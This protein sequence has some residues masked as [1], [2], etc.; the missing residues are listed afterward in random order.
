MVRDVL[1]SFFARCGHLFWAMWANL[2]TASGAPVSDPA[3]IEFGS[4]TRQIGDRRSAVFASSEPGSGCSRCLKSPRRIAKINSSGI[5]VRMK[6]FLGLVFLLVVTLGIAHAQQDADARYVS[7][8]TIIQQADNLADGGQ[9]GDALVA[10]TEAQARLEQFQ[11]LF[12]NWDPGIVSYRLDDLNKKIAA[13][14]TQTA[15]KPVV[16]APT[17]AAPEAPTKMQTELSEAQAQLQAA[18]NENRT[19]QA[20][21]KEALATQPAAVDAGELEAAQQQ[22]RDLMKQNEL[23]KSGQGETKVQTVIVEDTNKVSQLQLQLA[24]GMKKLTD[25]QKRAE[26]LIAENMAL[27]KN[28]AHSSSPSA[29]SEVL[30]SENDRLRTQLAALQTAANNAS[31]ADELATRLKDART[32]VTALQSAATL[33]A[34]EK[35]SL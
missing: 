30:Q 12:P 17:E 31:A 28:L 9:P 2:D 8:Y 34:L 35:A 3:G 18:Q 19:L 13:L 20:K 10:Y 21:L 25:E 1:V 15:P 14:K 32:Q 4:P 6:S 11:K 22:I 26:M 33:A 29:A 23:L 27:Q 16:T 5:L 7:I 24:A